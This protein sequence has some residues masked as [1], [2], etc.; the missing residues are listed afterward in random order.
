[1]AELVVRVVILRLVAIIVHRGDLQAAD[2]VNRGCFV[3]LGLDFNGIVIKL[4]DTGDVRHAAGHRGILRAFG[5][6]EAGLHGA[7]DIGGIHV[8]AVLR[9]PICSGIAAIDGV[10]FVIHIVD[11]GHR[12][13]EIVDGAGAVAG[14]RAVVVHFREVPHCKRV[15]GIHILGH[16]RGGLAGEH[17]GYV[18]I[19][20]IV[21]DDVIDDT[22]QVGF[23]FC[24]DGIPQSGLLILR[25]GVGCGPNVVGTRREDGVK[26][27]IILGVDFIGGLRL[28]VLESD[29]VIGAEGRGADIG[30]IG[31]HIVRED[32]VIRGHFFAVGE[33][34]ALFELDSV[35]GDISRFVIFDGDVARSG[36][37]VVRSVVRNRFTLDGVVD[38]TTQ[39]V[40]G[41]HGDLRHVHDVRV[42]RGVVEER[43]ELLGELAL[44]NYERNRA[45]LHLFGRGC[46]CLGCGFGRGRLRLASR[47]NAEAHD[48]CQQRRQD[49]A[50][51]F[52]HRT[53]SLVFC[54]DM[55]KERDSQLVAII[56]YHIERLWVRQWL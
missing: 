52:V 10:C 18:I 16:V 32:H 42:V 43:R 29:D 46:G 56:I 44:R 49:F 4:R 22:L 7:D 39:A 37:G 28:I 41:Q 5:G 51:L 47:Q 2:G 55:H 19:G 33:L 34:D 27:G 45:C 53:S 48:Q 6:D 3:T 13:G 23:P 24:L 50:G 8:A 38:D 31:K 25:P 21:G 36:I 35:G 1:M 14:Q 40:G 12:F 20:Q 17:G 30:R 11:G 9:C 15:S 54:W 26:Q